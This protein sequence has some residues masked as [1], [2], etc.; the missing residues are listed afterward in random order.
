[1]WSMG[2]APV[3][4]DSSMQHI[5][6]T[7][8]KTLDESYQLDVP[9]QHKGAIQIWSMLLGDQLR[10]ISVHLFHLSVNSR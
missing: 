5:A 3:G 6:M 4:D 7:A 8:Y 10:L 1:M 9:F 2:W